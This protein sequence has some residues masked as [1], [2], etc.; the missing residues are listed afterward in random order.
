MSAEACS[1]HLSS[2]YVDNNFC[3]L[4]EG[5]NVRVCRRVKRGGKVCVHPVV[6]QEDLESV[7]EEH[8]Q[9]LGHPGFETLYTHVS[10]RVWCSGRLP[11]L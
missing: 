7:F 3:L 6:A 9:A 8:H 2:E 1:T 10:P 4:G 11:G 5:S